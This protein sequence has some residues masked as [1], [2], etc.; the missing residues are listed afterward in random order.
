M[1][2]PVFPFRR[3]TGLWDRDV[4][5]PDPSVMSSS[6]WR[7]T[8]ALVCLIVAP[9]AQLAQ[10]LVSPVRQGVPVAVQ[11]SSAAAHPGAM[12]LALLL[13][14]PI[15]L[16]LPAILFAGMAARSRLGTAGAAVGFA[17]ALGAGYLLA[18]DVVIDAAARQSARASAV[19]LVSAYADSGAVTVLVALYLVGHVVGFALLGAA[20]IRSR[21]VPVWAGA[22]LCAW[23]VLEMLGEGLDVKPVAAAGF[24]ALLVGFAACVPVF[25]SDRGARIPA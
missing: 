6:Y 14:L 18:Q 8:A 23:P 21:T 1:S 16:I 15:L 25:L 17:T 3:D 9:L 24:V 5:S 4:S 10:Y 22:A 20:L 12:R 2:M 7:R 13:D 11:V 19:A